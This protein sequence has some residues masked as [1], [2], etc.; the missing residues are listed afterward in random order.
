MKLGRRSS[1]VVR[2]LLLT[3]IGPACQGSGGG[4][5]PDGGG[6][7]GPGIVRVEIT[8]GSVLLGAAGQTHALTAHAFDAQ[9]HEVPAT[10]TWTSSHP[11]Q[12][13][14]DSTGKLTGQ[15]IGSAQITAQ[16]SGI[17]SAAA[18]VLVAETAPGAVLVSDA[19][20]RLGGTGH[21]GPSR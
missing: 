14:V 8:P 5:N 9:N 12:V 20:V 6:T 7:P 19:Q 21:V 17:T 18:T 11:D 4:G 10:F 1:W 2:L 13:S 15:A 3:V 16:T